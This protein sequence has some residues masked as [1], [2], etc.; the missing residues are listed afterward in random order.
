MKKDVK[1]QLKEDEFVSTMTKI[2]HFIETRTHEIIIGLC[3]LALIAIL[4]VGLRLIQAQNLKRQSQALGQM[5]E[6]RSTIFTNPDNLA[7]LE[8]LQGKGRYGRLPYVL[9]STYWV[10]KGDLAKARD[11]LAKVGSSPR[12]FIYYQAQDLLGKVDTLSKNYDQAVAV[13]DKLEKDKAGDYTL[14]VVLFHKAEALEGKGD[15][16]GALTIYKKLQQD[17]PQSYFGYDAAERVRK[18]EGPGLPSM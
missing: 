9:L 2:L 7:K 16:Q 11:L 18:L 10:D 14:D 3:V 6:L 17:Y 12:D 4:F 15:R 1:K 8:Q 13:Y 5:L